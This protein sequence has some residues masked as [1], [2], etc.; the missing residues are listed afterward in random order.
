MSISICAGD[1]IVRDKEKLFLLAILED[2]TLI[3][4]IK[5]ERAIDFFVISKNAAFVFGFDCL[6]CR[7]RR[8][9]VRGGLSLILGNGTRPLRRCGAGDHHG[10]YKSCDKPES[11]HWVVSI[12]CGAITGKKANQRRVRLPGRCQNGSKIMLMGLNCSPPRP[13]QL[14]ISESISSG[15]Q[16]T[17]NKSINDP[18]FNVAED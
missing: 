4:V 8:R 5:I 17:I 10:Q 7:R 14:T 12:L 3:S 16:T 18:V 9:H 1:C 15:L 11:F 2:E 6:R 13:A